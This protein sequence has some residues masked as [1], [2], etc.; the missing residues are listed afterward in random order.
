MPRKP[1]AARQPSG[2]VAR[3]LGVAVKRLR[4]RL[5]EEAGLHATGLS[6]SQL[7]VLTTVVREG[8][9]TAARLAQLEHVSPQSVAQNLAVLKAAGL[10][11]GERDPDDG[12]K[13]LVHAREPAALLLASLDTQGQSFLARAIEQL[14][15][16]AERA[17]LERAI[18]LLERLA[19]ADLRP[20]G[21][22]ADR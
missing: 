5:R 15:P 22:S 18:E 7:G 21:D 1:P 17:D 12:R 20:P 19:A 16:D 10:V 9:V 4:S 6:I 2:A 11:R 8:P 3:R 14:V 13:V